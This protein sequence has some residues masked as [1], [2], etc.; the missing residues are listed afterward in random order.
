MEHTRHCSRVRHIAAVF[1][2]Y[3]ADLADRAIAI[4]GVDVEQNRNSARAIAF[5]REL[6]ISRARQLARAALDGPLDIILRH[7]LGLG[8]ENRAAQARGGVRISAAILGGNR[9]FLD[10]TGEDLAALGIER[11]LLMLDCGPLRVPRHGNTSRSINL[12]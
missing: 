8:G 5:E 11:A 3:V 6:L 10:Q 2:K 1:A 9:N 4:V 7:V 12:N